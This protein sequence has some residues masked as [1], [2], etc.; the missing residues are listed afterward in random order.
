MLHLFPS[1]LLTNTD[2][3]KFQL[4]GRKIISL[5]RMVRNRQPDFPPAACC[6]VLYPVL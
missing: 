6:F 1:A 3:K 4:P 2:G 5:Q